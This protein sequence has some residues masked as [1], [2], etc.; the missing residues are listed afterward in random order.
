MV[1]SIIAQRHSAHF[2]LDQSDV[3][4][5]VPV[6]REGVLRGLLRSA[7]W[8]TSNATSR[9]DPEFTGCLCD[10]EAHARPR[11]EWGE[12]Y[13]TLARQAVCDI[14]QDR[15]RELIDRHLDEMAQRLLSA[16]LADRAWRRR[17][18]GAAHPEVQ[19]GIGAARLRALLPMVSRW[20]RGVR[21]PDSRSARVADP[22]EPRCVE[23]S[24]GKRRAPCERH[25]QVRRV[26]GQ[27]RRRT[28]ALPPSA[29]ARVEGKP[30]RRFI[31][32]QHT[33]A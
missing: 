18:R 24:T 4:R 3:S 19:R 25:A 13:R 27:G 23:G 20:R 6:G 11:G 5:F 7:R 22:L 12:G 33:R 17:T 21:R 8:S 30:Q 1:T 16:P 31:V 32:G 26:Y 14:L 9:D 2:D 29:G 15:M 10:D 28:D